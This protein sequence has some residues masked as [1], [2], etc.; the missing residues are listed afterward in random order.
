MTRIAWLVLIVGLAPLAIIPSVARAVAATSLLELHYAPA[1]N[2][3]VLDVAMIGA[4][5]FSLDMAAFCLT[6]RAVIAALVAARTRGVEVRIVL[7]PSQRHAWPEL[8]ALGDSV[9]VRHKGPLMHLKTYLVDGQTLRTG[10][11]NFTASG[12]KHQ[13]NDLAIAVDDALALHFEAGFNRGWDYQTAAPPDAMAAGAP[14]SRV[15]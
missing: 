3:E 7:D 14:A 13:D 11:A 12:L 4:A 5:E 15:Q 2:L 8:Q 1:E 9:R 6:D 10:S